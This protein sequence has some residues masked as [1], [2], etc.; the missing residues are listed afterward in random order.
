MLEYDKDL[1]L[2]ILYQI[3]RSALTIM[4]RFEP[5]SSYKGFS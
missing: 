3:K 1:A 5:N 2:E 4:K